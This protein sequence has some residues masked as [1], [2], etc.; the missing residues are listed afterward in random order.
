ME[1]I[2][3]DKFTDRERIALAFVASYRLRAISL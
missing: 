3:V 2:L 1:R